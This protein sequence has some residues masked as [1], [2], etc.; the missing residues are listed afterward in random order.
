MF[1]YLPGSDTAAFR[2]ISVFIGA[3][4]TFGSSTAIANIIAGIIITYTRAFKKGDRL[5]IA[6]TTG[7]IVEKTLLVTRIR[8]IKYEV[9]SIPNSVVLQSH[10]INYSSSAYEPG[11]LLHTTVSIGYDTP[12]KQVNDLLISAALE[13][14]N[15]LK[16]PDPFILVLSLDDSFITY[17]LNAYTNIPS[18]MQNTYSDLHKNIVN[19]F[20]EA[21]VE[22]M[23]PHYASIEDGNAI[24]IP[25][26]YIDKSYESPSF[27]VTQTQKNEE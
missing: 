2:G 10:I 25:E 23:S 11:L 19:K 26:N 27:K 9:I 1:P 16:K 4:V 6:E 24:A 13:T 8:T 20:N 17:E 15:V 22:I 7:D 21:G 12:L 5:K 14:E 18:I 3:L